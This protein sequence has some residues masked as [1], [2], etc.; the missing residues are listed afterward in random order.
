M[1]VCEVEAAA[2]ASNRPGIRQYCGL[3]LLLGE[4]NDPVPQKG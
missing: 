4:W 3:N 1:V 2:G